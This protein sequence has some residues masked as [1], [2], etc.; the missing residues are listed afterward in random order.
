MSDK[1]QRR[2]YQ[3]D[4]RERTATLPL[5]PDCKLCGA[6]LENNFYKGNRST[7]KSCIRERVKKWADDNHEYVRECHRAKYLRKRE[8]IRAKQRADYAEAKRTRN[9]K[10]YARTMNRPVEFSMLYDARRRAKAKCV[11]CSIRAEDIVIPESC[12]I[13]G[14][15]LIRNKSRD[16]N[17]SSWSDNSP[18]LD[19]IIPSL[20]YVP[21]NV[22]VVSMRA[23]RIKTDATA[24]E[25]E[26]IAAYIRS[27]T[28]NETPQTPQEVAGAQS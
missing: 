23:N 9:W 12:P 24:H 10:K 4:Y 26:A 3:K 16:T 21:G 28:E 22:C 20:G 11:P 2:Q 1:A 8:D 13:L 19:R 27:H 17:R 15:P 7:C 5:R 6:S 25:L 14:I 18:S